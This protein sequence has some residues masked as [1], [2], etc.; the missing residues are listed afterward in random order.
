M[1][2]SGA[3]GAGNPSRRSGFGME[4]MTMKTT[5]GIAVVACAVAFSFAA[6]ADSKT[7]QVKEVMIKI[8][9]KDGVK[10]YKLGADM[11][12]VDIK[13][14]DHVTFDYADDTIDEIT[15]TDSSGDDTKGKQPEVKTK[16]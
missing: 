8:E 16:K 14:G 1:S 11:K 9:T 2:I 6:N 12:P 4:G 10:W 15:T 5:L 13:S 7:G 3:S